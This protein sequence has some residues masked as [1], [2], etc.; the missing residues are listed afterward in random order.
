MVASS[1]LVTCPC[2]ARGGPAIWIDS[3]SKVLSNEE[4]G[5]SSKENWGALAEI[6]EMDTKQT[7]R[8]DVPGCKAVY[9]SEAWGFSSCRCSRNGCAFGLC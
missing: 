9:L 2:L 5:N 6:G 8:T 7:K 1:S 3:P 4:S